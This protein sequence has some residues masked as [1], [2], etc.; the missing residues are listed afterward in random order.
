MAH[1]NTDEP[2][3]IGTDSVNGSEEPQG[4]ASAE[5][6]DKELL[7]QLHAATLKASDSCFEIKKLCATVVVPVGI[8]VA[9]FSRGQLNPAIFGAGLIVVS[10][11]WLA[12]ASAYYYQR[13]LRNLMA[14]I[15]SRRSARLNEEWP[16]APRE[17]ALGP[18]RSAFNPSMV[19]YLFVA[20]AIV[21]SFFLYKVG[22]IGEMYAPT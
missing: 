1:S 17:G 11:F 18:L 19:F 16:H 5:T 4:R 10:V 13:K 20:T 22:A 15:W 12:D 6:L 9:T 7:D 2:S 8:L 3:S 21:V 14:A